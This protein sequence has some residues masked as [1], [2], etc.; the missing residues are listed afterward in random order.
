M[1]LPGA[2]LTS[3][4]RVGLFFGGLLLIMVASANAQN[5]DF[6]LPGLDQ[7]PVRLADFRGRWVV[8]NFWATWCTPCLLEMPE[9]QAFHEQHRSRATVIGINHQDLEPGQI[10]AFAER[11]G[12]DFLIALSQGQPVAGFPLKGLPTTFLISPTGQLIDTHLG[13]VNATMLAQRLDELD[14]RVTP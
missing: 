9:L 14:K 12:V 11:L 8:V 2:R 10:R 13:T 4:I 6:S 1:R 7:R 3:S 5:P